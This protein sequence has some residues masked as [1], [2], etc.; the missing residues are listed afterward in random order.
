MAVHVDQVPVVQ[1]GTSHGSFVDAE[2]QRAD[3]VERRSGGSTQARN[4]AG[5]LRDFGL[6]E[7]NAE[8]GPERMGAKAVVL[9]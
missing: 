2:P 9:R 8:R 6:D 4:V 7:N 5:V 3:Q 1:P